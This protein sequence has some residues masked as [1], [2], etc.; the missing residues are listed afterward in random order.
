[1]FNFSKGFLYQNEFD[2][3][4]DLI[5]DYNANN[6]LSNYLVMKNIILE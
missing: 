4:F 3:L 6:L 1:M 5:G 2:N